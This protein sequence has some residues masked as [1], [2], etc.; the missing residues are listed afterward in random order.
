M[1]DW[2]IFALGFTAQLLFTSRF[3]F[4]WLASEKAKKVVTPSL[5]WKLSLSGSFLLLVYGVLRNDLPIVLGQAL[6][7][8]IYIRNLQL[9]G[10]WKKIPKL[11][12]V[13]TLLLPPIFLFYCAF[14][15]SFSNFFFANPEIPLWL[16]VLGLSGQAIFSFRF[17]VQW[18]Y[19]E[20]IKASVLPLPFW[21]LS[22]CGSLLILIYAIFRKDPVLFVGHL[23]G[24]FIYLRNFNLSRSTYVSG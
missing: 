23:A 18:L 12:R 16:L 15:S 7:F 10:E 14:S 24:S 9:Q 8:G 6:I 2:E 22:I 3:L 21:L 5:F 17:V 13:M 20:K 11:F 4:Q 19:S 1:N